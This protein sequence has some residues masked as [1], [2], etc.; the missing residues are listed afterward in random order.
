MLI[1]VLVH[2][3]SDGLLQSLHQFLIC[4]LTS[5]E[6]VF[7]IVRQFLFAPGQHVRGNFPAGDLDQ[8]IVICSSFVIFNRQ[9]FRRL[10]DGFS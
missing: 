7:V 5:L 6:Y 4:F 2:T 1:D 9:S 3:S 8:E 10:I